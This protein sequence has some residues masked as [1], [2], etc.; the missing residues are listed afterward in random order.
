MDANGAWL[1]PPEYVFEKAWGRWQGEVWH[2][3]DRSGLEGIL[4]SGTVRAAE[5]SGLNDHSEVSYAVDALVDAWGLVRGDLRPDAPAVEVD[6]WLQRISREIKR[7]RYFFVSACGDGDKL[8]HWKSYAGGTGYAIRF[9][10]DTEFRL[11]QPPGAPDLYF[12]DS[13]P[14]PYWRGVTYGAFEKWSRWRDDPLFQVIDHALDAFAALRDGRAVGERQVLESLQRRL[15]MCVC[16][17]KHPAYEEEEEARIAFAE[18]PVAQ[19]IHTREGRFPGA[20]T[21]RYLELVAADDEADLVRASL[22]R[23]TSLPILAVRIGPRFNREDREAGQH[24]VE[25]LLSECGYDGVH[26]DLSKIPY[27]G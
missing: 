7:S 20:P 10:T 26:V 1:S 18:P 19:Y 25:Q 8:A 11:K 27:R 15:L 21:V 3:T 24:L 4:R 22:D 17:H 13:A 23:P 2:Y 6:D 14:L 16:W 12:P 9:E 5:S